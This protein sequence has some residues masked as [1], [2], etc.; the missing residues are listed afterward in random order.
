MVQVR[1][2]DG[3][4][5]QTAYDAAGN[6]AEVRDA[7]GAVWRWNWRG[8]SL[9]VL[10]INPDGTRMAY[11]YDTEMRLATLTNEVGD[12]YRLEY[13]L[14]VSVR[15]RCGSGVFGLPVPRREIFDAIDLVIRQALEDPCEPR[16]GVDIVHLGG[17]DERVS[18]GS[19][20]SAAD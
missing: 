10:R 20:F 4:R 14:N 3:S 7:R 8:L 12:V 13:D 2:A 17:F 19:R 11:D 6:V 1:R 18:D 16:F 15:C 5:T 9:P